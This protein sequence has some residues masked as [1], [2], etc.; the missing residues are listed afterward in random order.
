MTICVHVASFH[1]IEESFFH[2][3]S[4]YCQWLYYSCKAPTR[5]PK[6]A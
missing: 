4:P 3:T 2:Q 5:S 6:I 1:L